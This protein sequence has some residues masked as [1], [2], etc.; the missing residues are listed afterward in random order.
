MA[1]RAVVALRGGRMTVPSTVAML[2]AALALAS[3]FFTATEIALF[4]I[5][6]VDR[7]WLASDDPAARRA[8]SLLSRRA[9]LLTTLLVGDTAANVALVSLA[10]TTVYAWR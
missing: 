9:A 4:T 2:A 10:V 6:R 1:G 8:S 3:V 7:K 5:H